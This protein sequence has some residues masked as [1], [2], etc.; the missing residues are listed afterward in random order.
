MEIILLE[1]VPNLGQMGDIVTVKGGF[2]RNFLLPQGKALPATKSNLAE[3]ESRRK[4]L[5]AENATKRKDAEKLAKALE[6]ASVKIER[7]AS[8][9]GQ[10]YG[11]VK[12]GDLQKALTEMGHD[13]PK[14]SVQLAEP[15]KTI[16]DFEADVVLHP[17]VTIKVPVNVTRQVL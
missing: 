10:L 8:E 17:E 4:E 2:A 12:P 1:R 9:V 5:E 14:G 7:Q 13:V 3:F 11:S 16:G 15:I 6:S